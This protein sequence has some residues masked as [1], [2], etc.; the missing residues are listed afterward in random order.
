VRL[1]NASVIKEHPWIN[2]MKWDDLIAKKI[3][4]PFIPVIKEEN[5]VSNFAPEFTNMS[6][7]SNADSLS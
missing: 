6:P 1:K 7:T 2:Q 3:K 4:P 5:D